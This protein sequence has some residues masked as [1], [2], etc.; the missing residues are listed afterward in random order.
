M[1][2][3][4][5]EDSK[6]I[7]ALRFLLIVFVVFI[8]NNLNADDAVNYY[9]LAFDEPVVITWLKY[10]VCSELGGAAVPLFFLFAGYLQFCK[11]ERYPVL[12]KKRAK[13]LL[14]PYVAW[15]LLGVLAFF[16]GQSV[17]PLAPFFQNENNIVR[18]WNAADWLGLFWVHNTD[19]SLYTPL[20]YQLWFM[21]DL[22]VL[23]VISPLLQWLARKA[24]FAVAV[25]ITLCFLDGMPLGF[26]T[27]LF[28]YM[29]GWY[30]AERRVSFFALADKITW[31]EYV[32]LLAFVLAVH[33]A[34]PDAVPL[35]GLGTVISC[36]FFLR[37]SGA[38]AA[39]GWLF[40]KARYL[41]GY[42]FFL[43]AIHAP[44]IVNF[45]N[46]VSYR[47]IP[48]HGAWCLVQFVVPCVLCVVIGTGIGIGLKR[49]L[50]PVFA[51]LNG[52]RKPNSLA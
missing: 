1:Q 38:I 11:Q 36:L 2:S 17:P 37:L 40:A 18:N 7:T 9:H 27:A 31:L 29:A 22:M 5:D 41:A 47:V 8:H 44:F 49:L 50:P 4:T 19:S 43:Y 13:S 39:H 21:R 48:L 6:R 35:H 51:L 46:K 33:C 26:G 45:L 14:A 23:V 28:F 16:V 32:L 52:S 12:L 25:A 3:I 24:P 15:T 10:L 30:C 34:V 42:S 20:V